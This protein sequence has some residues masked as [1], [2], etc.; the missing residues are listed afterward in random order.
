MEFKSNILK[1]LNEHM[2]DDVSD[3]KTVKELILELGGGPDTDEALQNADSADVSGDVVKQEPDGDVIKPDPDGDVLKPDPDGDVFDRGPDGAMQDEAIYDDADD[4]VSKLKPGELE[5][6][7]MNE[8]DADNMTVETNATTPDGA[9][10]HINKGNTGSGKSGSGPDGAVAGLPEAPDKKRGQRA[11]KQNKPGKKDGGPVNRAVLKN[12]RKR[13]RRAWIFITLLIIGG[14]GFFM[15]SSVAGSVNNAQHVRY[16]DITRGDLKSV[17]SVRGNVQ[18]EVKRNVY[19]TLALM[20]KSVE[21]SVGDPVT[22]GQVLCLLDREDLELNIAQQNAELNAAILNSEKQIEQSEK[23]L[24]DAEANL[25]S[26]RNAQILNAESALRNAKVSLDTAQAN[27]NNLQHDYNNGTNANRMSAESSLKTAQTDFETRTRDYENNK[28]LLAAGA[29]SQEAMNQSETAYNN[30]QSRLNDALTNLDNARI[31]EERALEQSRNTLRSAQTAHSNAQIALTSAQRAAEQEIE[32]YESNVEVTRIGA[33]IEARQIALQ[34]LEKQMT[35]SVIKSPVN[36]VVTAVYAKEGSSG[37]GLLFI[38]EDPSQM[39]INIRV[40]EYDAGKLIPGM[41]V[42]IRADAISGSEYYGT[43]TKID[44]AA[45]KNAMGETDTISDIEFGAEVSVDTEDTLLRIG[46]NARLDIILE[47]RDNVF[48]IPF[49]TVTENESGDT[50]IYVIEDAVHEDTN[51]DGGRNTGEGGGGDGG[52][53]SG[54]GA[55]ISNMLPGVASAIG[56]AP[57]DGDA[58]YAREIPVVIGL[59]TDFYVEIIG[60]GL[61]DELRVI[62][63]ATD[64]WLYDGAPI[65]YQSGPGGSRRGN[66]PTMGFNFGGM[67]R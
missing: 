8:A 4:F 23:T 25:E 38:I 67:R 40:K 45:V 6:G 64:S 63:E 3:Y 61:N 56:L 48:Y 15:Y 20:V 66:A 42:M 44:P 9:G 43:L 12:R 51:G 30:A 14:I 28:L 46:M 22:E 35:D 29:I 50:V 47:Q 7:G 18:S 5:Y 13:K 21:V 58:S 57:N 26:G 24:S 65:S 41:P 27:Y 52:L 16:T 19:S 31:A 55:F 10:A 32:R 17:I 33:N 11:G 53:L 2:G 62:N 36:G 49:D 37:S 60:S 54:A 59:E 34:K 1:T 39:K